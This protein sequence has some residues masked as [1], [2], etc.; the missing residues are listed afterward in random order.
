MPII[1]QKYDKGLFLFH[2]DLRIQDNIG[3]HEA[4]L[5]CKQLYT[6]FIFTPEQV[7]KSNSYKSLNAIQFMIE[8]LADLQQ[9][10]QSHSGELILL[11][12]KTNA[13]LKEFIDAHSIDAVFFNRDYT[14]Y[15]M[16][17]DAE[18][19][20]LCKKG[21]I[22]CETAA[23]YYLHDLGTVKNNQGGNYHKFT[24]YYETSLKIHVDEP[25]STIPKHLAKPENTVKNRISLKDAMEKMVPKPN[26]NILVR[27]GRGQ[28][29]HRLHFVVNN[30]KEYEETRN[31][32]TMETTQLSAY[33]K[34]GC[35]SIRE[36]FH[37][38]KKRFG[39]QHEILRE[40]IWRDFFA[41]LL[42]A[43]PDALGH[44]YSANFERIRWKTNE[45]WLDR[46]KTGNTGFPVVDACMRQLN[47]TGYMHNRGRMIVA[48][49]LVKT[50]LIDWR[51]GE[52]YFAQQLTDYDVASNYG[53]WASIV[54]GGA[55]SMPYFRVMN[56]WI[57][58]EKFDRDTKYIRKWVPELKDVES[59]DIHKWSTA[60]KNAKYK[61]IN[62]PAPMVD[63]HEQKEKALDLYNKYL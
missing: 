38:I 60:Y 46:W 29:M 59:K 8:S 58:S 37:T 13:V 62:Y 54:G 42:F 61:D 28:A 47:T 16:K 5:K 11:Y 31:D 30:L 9:S 2:R 33:I 41:Q 63:Y 45:R 32:L 24:A 52:R 3:L 35:I 12:G 22:I 25:I 57:Q 34:F 4:A 53:N 7:G 23:D 39:I 10:L 21:G 49:F 48:Q 43:Y 51:E 56:P 40:L 1:R 44:M 27:G 55:Y 20:S 26:P 18:I 17:R 36:V 50:L 6:L 15:A 14:P 19:E